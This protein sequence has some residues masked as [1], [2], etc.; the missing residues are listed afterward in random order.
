MRGGGVSSGGLSHERS[1]LFDLA[2]SLHLFTRL[3]LVTRSKSGGVTV[4]SFLPSFPRTRESRLDPG[5]ESGVT[6]DRQ[7]AG[8]TVTCG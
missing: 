4:A 8:A 3:R 5:S 6:I 7:D 2:L 1:P